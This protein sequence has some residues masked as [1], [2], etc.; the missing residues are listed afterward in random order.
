MKFVYTKNIKFLLLKSAYWLGQKL[1]D[2]ARANRRIPFLVQADVVR[3]YKEGDSSLS[4]STV[5]YQAYSS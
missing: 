5:G 3:A 1:P 4:T 2:S